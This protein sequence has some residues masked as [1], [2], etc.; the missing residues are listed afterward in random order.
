MSEATV[1]FPGGTANGLGLLDTP[2][3]RAQQV[4]RGFR[5]E[6]SERCST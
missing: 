5:S 2:K 4:V 1:V 3:P 6:T